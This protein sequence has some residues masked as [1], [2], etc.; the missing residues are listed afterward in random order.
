[1]VIAVVSTIVLS[2]VAQGLSAN[3]LVATLGARVKR[4]AGKTSAGN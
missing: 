1:M 3:P 2:V 4:S